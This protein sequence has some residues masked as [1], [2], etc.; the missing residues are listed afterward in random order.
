MQSG[1]ILPHHETSG[2][3]L[4]GVVSIN[5][6][7]GQ[8]FNALGASLTGYDP[9]HF[10]AVALRVFIE[11]TPVVTVYAMDK[12][13]RQ[14]PENADR[15]PVRKFKKEMSFDDLFFKLRQVNFTVST[16]EQSIDD[17]EVVNK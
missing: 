17:M 7:E 2:K 10:E 12:A 15:M 1:R 14:R 5:L 6:E 13:R 11:N 8:D 9:A 3:D 16:G 4:M